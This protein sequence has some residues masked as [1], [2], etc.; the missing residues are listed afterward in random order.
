M[1][2]AN[3]K[4]KNNK[5]QT[6]EGDMKNKTIT[7]LFILSLAIFG[8][9]DFLDMQPQESMDSGAALS[10]PANVKATLIGA[11][12]ESR[13]RWLFGSQFN[14]YSELLATT[15][16]MQHVG[17]HRQPQ[18]MLEKDIAVNNSYVES[19]WITAYSLINTINHVVDAV[20]ILDAQDQDRVLGEALF[21]R[22][23]TY[24]ELTRLWGLPYVPGQSNDQPGVPLIL[25]PTKGASQAVPV[26]RASV[27]ECYQQVISDLLAARELLPVQNGIF[28][29]SHA[30]SAILSR[31]YLQVGDHEQAA[32]EAGRVI[33]SGAYQLN[34]S[35]LA[36]FN[37]AQPSSEDIFSLQ[38]SLTSNT[39]WL[40]ERYGSLNGLGRGDY[41]FSPDFLDL[42]D[43]NDLR[44]QLQGDTHTSYT[45][46]NIIK[47]YYIGVGAIRNGGIN[48]AKWGNYYTA[49]PLVRLAEMY[50]TR[51][52]ANFELMAAGQAPQ[53][54]ASP[55]EDINTIRQRASA[56][57]YE[58]E[59]GRE[60]IRLERYLELCWEGHRLHDLKRWQLDVGP[61]AFDAG[62]L[63]LPI[64]VRE[65]ETNPLLEQNDHYQ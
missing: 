44:G 6:A 41:Q 62:N 57:L 24:F 10:T 54:P 1:P 26:E 38:N 47:M 36:A 64:P 5:Q 32:A 3:K 60:E 18:E 55:G 49:I 17:S 12:L 58:N 29:N 34:S 23:L 31:V 40:P 30:A 52:E 4:S 33:E 65:M 42:Y 45:L 7:L 25:S 43:G 16:H 13:S 15:G 27:H 21:L 59:P 37:N 61:H 50:L 9:E 46:E 51:A 48:T 2:K 39:I 8:C 53:G 22:G 28:A 63:I 20:D 14:E 11:Y 56:P 35:P 19:T